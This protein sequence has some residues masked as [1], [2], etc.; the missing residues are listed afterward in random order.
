MERASISDRVAGFWVGLLPKAL[1]SFLSRYRAAVIGAA[2]FVLAFL[3]YRLLGQPETPYNNFVRLSDAFLHGRYYLKENVL[4][5]ELIIDNGKYYVI[6]PPMPAIMLIPG[7]I[8]FGLALNQTLVSVVMGS[9]TAASVSTLVGNLTRK[10]SNQVWL[11]ILF[12]FGTVYWFAAAN[13]G[14]WFFSHT[15]AVFFLIVAIYFTLAKPNPLMAGICLGAAFLT[16][17]PTILSFPFFLI[18][19]SDQ[20]LPAAEGQTLRQRFKLRPLIYV[21]AG[22][23][24]FILVSFVYNYLRFGTPLDVSQNRLPASVLAQPWFNHGPFSYHYISRHTVVAFEAMP[25][26]QTNAP[27]VIPSWG[28][29][30]IWAST[31]AFF[32]AFFAGTKDKRVWAFGWLLIAVTTGIIISKGIARAWDTDWA[33]YAFPYQ[34]NLIPFYV[35]IGMAIW[36]GRK[37]KQILACWAA[38]LPVALMLF[39]FAGTGFSQFGY[40]FSLD[41]MPFLFLLT[42]KGMGEKLSWHQK[43]LIL[44]SVVANL[45]GVVWIYKFDQTHYLGLLWSGF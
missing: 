32:Y 35:L 16:R 13:G 29:M 28:G 15:I 8:L 7:V 24:F 34:W 44:L 42:I 36:T 2:F 10:L 6:P 11:T 45:W 5:I 21:S 1:R 30:A 37:D 4:W 26:V 19:F 25:I 41:F 33:N 12:L 3:V 20:W 23:V 22:I 43:T 31:P 17:A 39:T 14:V 27:Y 38:I 9:L 18:M 40:R